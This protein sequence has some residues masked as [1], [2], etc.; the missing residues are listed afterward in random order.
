MRSI[1]AALLLSAPQRSLF[2]TALDLHCC[3]DFL[4]VV[5]GDYSLVAG[6]S[7]SLWCFFCGGTRVLVR[8]SSVVA[9]RGLSCMCCLPRPR[10]KPMSPA[11]AG[12]LLT[13]GPPGKSPVPFG[14]KGRHGQFRQR[15]TLARDQR[16]AGGE[17][18]A[19]LCR[20]LSASVPL[21]RR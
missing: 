11:L 2:L 17:P 3:V 15:E 18:G 10:I 1:T 21:L 8:A 20:F 14:F 12:R 16:A 7:Y 6:W 9:T 5:S 13:T 19:L 4:G